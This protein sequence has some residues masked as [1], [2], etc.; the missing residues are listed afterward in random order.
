MEARMTKYGTWRSYE[1]SSALIL[2]A[3]LLV[4]SVVLAYLGTRLHHRL[5]VEIPGKFIKFTLVL[6]FLLSGFSFLLADVTY[7]EELLRQVGPITFPKNPISPVTALSGL[8]TFIVI[9]LLTKREGFIKAFGNAIVGTIAAP[10]I[11]ELPFDLIVS[12]RTYPPNPAL[13]YTLLF[14]LPLFAVEIT[15]YA[16]LSFSSAVKLSKYTLFSFAGMFFVFTV[17]ALFGF[18]YPFT[19]IPIAV[20][21]VS[22]IL[23]FVTAITLFL[24]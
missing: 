8:I 4:V 13:R 12:S 10:L 11:F 24:P 20:N 21:M 2:A 7:I 17:W 3:I 15:S 16:M 14:F 18:E 1:G 5:G 9:I 22:K 6:V 19:G 23:S